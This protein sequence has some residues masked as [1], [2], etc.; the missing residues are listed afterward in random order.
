MPPAGRHCWG[1]PGLAVAADLQAARS[2]FAG[3]IARCDC[4]IAKR[5]VHTIS[6]IA[7]PHSGCLP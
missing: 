6:Y 2:P 4:C 5:F 3:V 7:T 1:G